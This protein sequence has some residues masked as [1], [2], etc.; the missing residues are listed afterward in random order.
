MNSD[1]F[2]IDRESNSVTVSVKTSIFPLDVIY[3]ASYVFL[4]RAYII[5]DGN[6]NRLVN[7][8]LVP[9]NNNDPKELAMEFNNEL[10]SYSVHKKQSE[11]NAPIREAII[12][13][14]L[15]TAEFASKA[16]PQDI[17]DFEE[18]DADFI[19]DPEGIAIPWE[20][21]FGDKK[22]EVKKDDKKSE[23]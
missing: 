7:I 23:C 14:A 21:K 2:S 20:E 18:S 1:N 22:K 17:P 3:S 12:Q 5:L 10:L 4:D 16:P 19:E 11:K 13:R 9:K 8:R 6:P 15:L